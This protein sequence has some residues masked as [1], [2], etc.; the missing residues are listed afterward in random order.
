MCGS[1]GVVLDGLRPS[2]VTGLGAHLETVRRLFCDTRTPAPHGI[3]RE[4]HVAELFKAGNLQDEVVVG[5]R[6]DEEQRRGEL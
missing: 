6:P 2:Q 5:I 1:A 4:P 3:Y